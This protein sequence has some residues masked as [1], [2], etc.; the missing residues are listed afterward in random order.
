MN[1]LAHHFI[2]QLFID[3]FRQSFGQTRED[4]SELAVVENVSE[5]LC[6]GRSLAVLLHYY[7]PANISLS[8]LVYYIV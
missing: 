4:G 3:V 1:N 5:D 8:G 7:C 6:D 2:H